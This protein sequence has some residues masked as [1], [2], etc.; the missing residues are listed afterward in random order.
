M[1]RL[2]Q[3]AMR[4][5]GGPQLWLYLNSTVSIRCRGDVRLKLSALRSLARPSA[6]AIWLL[7]TPIS[8]RRPPVCASAGLSPAAACNSHNNLHHSVGS[9]DAA[10]MT[11]FYSKR[12]R[13]CSRTVL[14]LKR[15]LSPA[16]QAIIL[17]QY[18]SFDRGSTYH[19]VI[20]QVR[21][22]GLI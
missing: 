19:T 18:C 4:V 16:C 21:S 15:I 2:S 3:G 7:Q 12:L 17:V 14:T 10:D 13:H 1:S 8:A 6:S 5:W 11:I 20:T 9:T 22:T